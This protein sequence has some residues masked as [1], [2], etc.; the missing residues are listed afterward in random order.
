MF[1]VSCE[2][3][4]GQEDR[5]FLS[6]RGAIS[7]ARDSLISIGIEDDFEDLVNEGFVVVSAL[8]VISDICRVSGS[9]DWE[10]YYLDGVLIYQAH[11]V[12]ARLLLENLGLPSR[13]IEADDT[14]LNDM[15]YL[16]DNI[17][18]VKEA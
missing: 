13:S 15:G 6:E 5:V 9:S 3:D 14:W 1:K 10:G 12:P 4:I 2:W 16:P 17:D 8:T 11:S 7:W 18:D